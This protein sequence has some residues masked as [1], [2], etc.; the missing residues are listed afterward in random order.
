MSTSEVDR[1]SL[2]A[3]T[4]RLLKN[5]PKDLT[6]PDIE[7]ATQIP[8]YWLRKFTSGEIKDPSVNRV[9]RLYEYLSGNKLLNQA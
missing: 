8:F 2:M 4:L 5:R 9:Q 3:E 7:K 1:G 6:L